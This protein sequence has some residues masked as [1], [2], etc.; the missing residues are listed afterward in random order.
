[1]ELKGE[2]L[3]ELSWTFYNVAENPFNG[4]ESPRQTPPTTATTH[5]TLGI[6]SMELKETKSLTKNMIDM[7]IKE[8]IQWN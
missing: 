3:R 4:I 1:M 2:L 6:H 5:N 7:V 8:S